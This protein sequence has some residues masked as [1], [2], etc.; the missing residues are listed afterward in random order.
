LRTKKIRDRLKLIALLR[1]KIEELLALTQSQEKEIIVLAIRE[2]T[3]FVRDCD[4][5][6][7]DSFDD[8][9]IVV[10]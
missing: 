5:P 10:I 3:N 9:L 4:A 1:E 2:K 7:F 6:S 8:K